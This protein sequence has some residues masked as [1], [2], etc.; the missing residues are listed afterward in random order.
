MSCAAVAAAVAAA[1]AAVAAAAAAVAAAVAAVRACGFVAFE[2]CGV[3][4]KKSCFA[5]RWE[6]Y[7]AVQR[8]FVV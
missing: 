2:P 4:V 1:A 7:D 5:V 6:G 3:D 8:Y